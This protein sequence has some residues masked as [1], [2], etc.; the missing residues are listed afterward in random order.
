MPMP[1]YTAKIIIF[2]RGVSYIKSILIGQT[3][4]INR[5]LWPSLQ[6]L[7]EQRIFCNAFL[8][9]WNSI[10]EN[11]QCWIHHHIERVSSTQSVYVYGEFLYHGNNVEGGF[12]IKC[13]STTKTSPVSGMQKTRLMLISVSILLECDF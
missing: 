8:W 11:A 10:S 1:T 7:S 9:A 13:C 12:P 4:R 5:L 6:L 2:S 3:F